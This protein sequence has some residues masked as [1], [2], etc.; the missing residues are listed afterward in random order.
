V[1][2]RVVIVGSSVGGVRTARALRAEGYT[3]HITLV[4]EEPELPYD[5][6]P[7]SK[8]VL[9]GVWPA[10]RAGLLTA[11]AAADAGIELRL[12]VAARSLDTE[13]RQV[14]LA[15]GEV[16]PYDDL[17]IA[18]GA[19]AR[20]SPWQPES[21]V[22]TLRTLADCLALK[23]CFA[24]GTSVVLIGGGF[25]GAEAAAAARSAGCDVTLVDAVAV[26]MERAAGPVVG[27]LLA[28]VQRGNGVRTRFGVGVQSVTG[29]AGNLVVT[30]S[31]ASVVRAEAVVV[32]IG[33]LPNDQWLHGSGLTIGDGVV[34]DAYLAAAGA[35]HVF[36]IGDVARWPHPELDAQVRS[37]HWTNAADQARCV[38]RTIAQPG[39]REAY[40]PSD[41]IWSD[42]YD[43][44]LQLAGHRS[45]AIAEWVIGAP[46]AQ[47]P[48]VTVLHGDAAGRLCGAVCLNWPKAFVQCR[49][50][51]DERA[52]A[53]QARELLG[54]P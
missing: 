50:L 51:L 54:A 9:T 28:D 18:T 1:R 22:Y 19:S 42:Q 6:P 23:K 33:A 38:A 53:E 32:G 35:A 13:A 41:Y 47:R 31:D 2:H 46:G 4:G 49:R 14:H 27:A 10:E 17:V 20:P 36:A 40:Q 15:D 44:K 43:W 5:R 11:Q 29:R 52:P 37:E 30:L 7:L 8:Q 21:G 39:A 45:R 12:G 26:P 48:Q 24:D 16:L 34:C 3:G 25:I